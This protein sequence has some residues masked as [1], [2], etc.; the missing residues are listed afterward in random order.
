MQQILD[1]IPN[2][3]ASFLRKQ[4]DHSLWSQLLNKFR[5]KAKKVNV[6]MQKSS[7]NAWVENNMPRGI[8]TFSSGWHDIE[9][10]IL[11]QCL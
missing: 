6:M 2:L 1:S 8:T 11:E 3:A 7:V 10:R 9:T 4:R 5:L